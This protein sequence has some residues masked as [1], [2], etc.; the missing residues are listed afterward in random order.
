M[1]PFARFRLRTAAATGDIDGFVTAQGGTVRLPGAEV[2][3]KDASDRQV[4]RVFCGEDGH[5]RVPD[6]PPGSYRVS[7]SLDGFDTGRAD[8]VVTAGKTTSLSIDL[9]ISSISQTVD[10]AATNPGGL[11]QETLAPADTIGGEEL[12][13]FA[14]GGGLQSELRL[15]ASVIEVPGGVSIK[16]GRPGQ[17]GVQ[18]GA[19]TL[20]DPSTGLTQVSC[21]TTRSI[22]SRCCRIRTP[23]ST[24]DS[25]RGSW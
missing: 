18:L 21:R 15:L 7:G 1:R 24:A 17:A 22:R 4:A 20:V 11:N 9:S 13:Q 14:P 8:T 12:D 25:R 6:L 16:G 10:V 3:V 19:G 2:T 23:S 5:F